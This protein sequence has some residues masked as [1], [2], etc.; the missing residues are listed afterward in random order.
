MGG[1]VEN[2]RERKKKNM[3]NIRRGREEKKRY[4]KKVWGKKKVSIK[5]NDI[6]LLSPMTTIVPRKTWLV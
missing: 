3:M 4:E 6:K 2:K 5:L 1:K